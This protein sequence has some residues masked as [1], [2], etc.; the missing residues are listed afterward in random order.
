M[1]GRRSTWR[2]AAPLWCALLLLLTLVVAGCRDNPTPPDGM[3]EYQS[4]Q[5][6]WNQG[7]STLRYH[8]VRG[9][10]TQQHT[11]QFSMNGATI[12]D[13]WHDGSGTSLGSTLLSIS[14]AN[15]TVMLGGCS[16]ATFWHVPD[17]YQLA[18]RTVTGTGP[19]VRM[20]HL[21]A[22][23][24]GM[25]L[26]ADANG[27]M[28]R[29][30]PSQS[31]WIRERVDE[32]IAVT[33]LCMDSTSENR[34]MFAGSSL[35]GV[36]TRKVRDSVWT[37]LPAPPG[38]VEDLEADNSNG[39]FAVINNRL[40]YSTAPFNV[41]NALLVQPGNSDI[42]DIAL[43]RYSDQDAIMFVGTQTSGIVEMYVI[44][45]FPASLR[46]GLAASSGPIRRVA[47]NMQTAF[48][49]AAITGSPSQLLVAVES[50]LWL[51]IS[52]PG[53]DLRAV[54]QS[55]SGANVFVATD[56]GVMMYDGVILRQRGLAGQNV[57]SVV[58]TASG[59]L[60]CGTEQGT[61]RSRDEGLTWSRLDANAFTTRVRSGFVMLPARLWEGWHWE[62]GA[63]V[64]QQGQ[65]RSI[66]GRVMRH[67]DELILPDNG[68]R[69]SDVLVVRYGQEDEAGQLRRDTYSW[70]FYFARD[71]GPVLIEEFDGTVLVATSSVRSQP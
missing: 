55:R 26:V 21:L 38:S 56:K 18:E 35:D 7:Q 66:K 14:R 20:T 36:Y 43:L 5:Y 41:W 23:D 59:D 3:P 39:L 58:S 34:R 13:D 50:G 42:T 16:A 70:T 31:L 45:G 6:L 1:V 25:L 12:R 53:M 47:A 49:V 40:Y 8:S 71:Y 64:E 15:G 61:W 11:L 69:Y 9:G 19:T 27:G 57:V 48:P 68:G 28:Y 63:L 32:S 22:P 51:S 44:S 17:R 30:I 60:Y 33:A 65:E 2:R 4:V 67:L 52:V 29:Y 10:L 24:N 54:T 37:K 46:Y 62:A